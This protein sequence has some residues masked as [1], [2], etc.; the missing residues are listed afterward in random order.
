MFSIENSVVK[1]LH[2]SHTKVLALKLHLPDFPL[3]FIQ[4]DQLMLKIQEHQHCH[5]HILNAASGYGKSLALA[6]WFQIRRAEQEAITWLTL[7]EK[8]NDPIRLLTYLIA[9]LKNVDASACN[10][11]LELLEKK[12]DIDA[13]VDTLIYEMDCFLGP[14]HFALDD[15]QTITNPFC[16]NIFDRILKYSKGN[17]RFYILSQLSTPLNVTRLL[18]EGRYIEYSES[19]LQLN[20]QEYLQ[21]FELE[22]FN[23]PTKELSASFY[24]L[25]QGWFVGLA[26]LKQVMNYDDELSLMG[27]EKIITDYLAAQWRSKI[28]EDE[29]TICLHLAALNKANGFYMD[30]VFNREGSQQALSS[31]ADKHVHVL[32]DS[33]HN[34]W[35][36]LHP[37]LGRFLSHY[38]DD[39]ELSDQLDRASEWLNHHKLGVDAVN[40]ALRSGSQQQTANILEKN[41]ESI[42]EKHDLAQLLVWREQLPDEVIMSSPKLVIIFSWTLAFAQQFDEAER[43][44]A[45][46]DRQ[47][48]LSKVEDSNGISGQLFAIRGYIARCRGKMSNAIQLCNQ[49]LEKLDSRHYIA[50]SITYFNLSNVYMSQD[51]LAQSRHYNRL[52]FETAR[53]ARSIHLEMQALH[54][55]AR[56]EQVRGNLHLAEKLLNEGLS[57]SKKLCNDDVAAPYGRLLIYKGYILW[58]KNKSKES[59]SLLKQGIEIAERNHDAYIIMGYVL[60]N[61][62]ARQNGHVEQAY[63]WLSQVESILQYWSVPSFIYQPWLSTM[64]VNLQIDENKIETAINN[65]KQLYASTQQNEYALSP[66]H[67]PGLRRLC[68][69][70]YVRAKSFS[71][72]HSKALNLLDKKLEND[73]DSQQGFSLIFRL[74]MRALLRY[75]LGY[76]DNALQD[77]RRA[78][79]L[80]EKDYCIMPFIEYSQS[81][82]A[83]YEQL[84]EHIQEMPFVQ[85]IL[86]N[87]N[88]QEQPQHNQSFA[89]VRMVISQREMAVLK[90][91]AE[92]LS[93]QEIAERLF[94]SLH[95]VKTH[96]RRINAKLSVK[97]RTQAII[98]AREVGV[99]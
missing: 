5:L 3:N 17:I 74:L 82:A 4:R 97:S 39:F 56:I 75:Q 64:R 60:L 35:V 19:D 23:N 76:E 59:E 24:E 68:D 72:Q 66:E 26:L 94:I 98:K 20:K 80:A 51:K 9:A 1:T 65:L 15:F 28:T 52:S 61:N 42:F 87:I 6:Q 50:K 43:L 37:I 49:A 89:K 62:I 21:W 33:H 77:F 91:I 25:S 93:N 47:F 92:G 85:D 90:L 46:M 55:H 8:E 14:V 11:S 41:A 30:H 12:S 88:L 58:L 38:I 36:Y 40:M 63:D 7:D 31:L 57:L 96:A 45:Q 2:N 84:P 70:F 71:G 67:Y 29:Y 48:N 69:V 83:L 95:T 78:L 10:G 22:N 18:G 27:S 81:M 34:D 73:G 32:R 99:I 13:I 86:S 79:M 44:L 53:A 54:E 16:I